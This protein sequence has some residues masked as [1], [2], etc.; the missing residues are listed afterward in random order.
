MH[1]SD[2]DHKNPGPKLIMT[3]LSYLSVARFHGPDAGEFLHA[4]LSAD[5]SALE[6]GEATYACYCSVRGQVYGLLL[7]SRRADDYLLA[8][9]AELLPVILT[10]LRMFVLRSRVE[11]DVCP[12]ITVCGIGPGEDAS[13]PG[14]VQPVEG[15]RYSLSKQAMTEDAKDEDFKALE[16]RHRVSWL[17]AGTTEKFIPQMLGF[18]R[19]GA[20]SFS[21]GCY[22]GQEIVARARY[23]GKVKRKPVVVLTEN[24]AGL[25]PGERLELQRGGDWSNGTVIDSAPCGSGTCLMIVASAEPEIAPEALKHQER[26]YRCATM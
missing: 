3:P 11:F 20:V 6:T 8:A 1:D 21:K 17:N 10:R 4:Q 25:N 16:I 19:I 23:L 2:S 5:I 24:E 14:V 13:I 12:D 7:V 15:L 22:P 18:D 26:V 9:S